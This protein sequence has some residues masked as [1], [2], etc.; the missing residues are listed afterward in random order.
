VPLAP[1]GAQY[2]LIVQKTDGGFGYASTDMAAIK[3]RV[4]DEKADWIIYVT[5]MGQA[6]H[7]DLVSGGAA[8]CCKLARPHSRPPQQRRKLESGAGI[9]VPLHGA[10]ALPLG[11][12]GSSTAAARGLAAAAPL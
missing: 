10:P 11:R 6:T 12:D 4:H 3:H 8:G 5:D 1:Q 9:C 2:P 7:F